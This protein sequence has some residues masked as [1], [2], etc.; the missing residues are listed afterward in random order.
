MS[1]V[2]VAGLRVPAGL[3]RA[4][5]G[6]GTLHCDRG[7]RQRGRRRHPS[8]H[9]LSDTIRFALERIVRGADL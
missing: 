5:A 4:A 2:I 3:A 1:V 9:L 6:T 8:H 7:V